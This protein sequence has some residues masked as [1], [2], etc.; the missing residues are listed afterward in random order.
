M[1]VEWGKNANA[2]IFLK[3]VFTKKTLSGMFLGHH[4]N[5]AVVKDVPLAYVYSE[6]QWK[7]SPTCVGLGIV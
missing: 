2:S 4:I 5:N 1:D 3:D 7:S 6:K